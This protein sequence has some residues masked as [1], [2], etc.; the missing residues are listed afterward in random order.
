M[1]WVAFVAEHR[2]CG[3]LDGGMDNGFVCFNARVDEPAMAQDSRMSG[4]SYAISTDGPWPRVS[5]R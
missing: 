2:R 1:L 4:S 5:S 3:V